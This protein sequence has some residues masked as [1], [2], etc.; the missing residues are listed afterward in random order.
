MSK[1]FKALQQAELE[2]TRRTE[3]ERPP[4][5]EPAQPPA[6]PG[7]TVVEPA[8]RPEA[9]TERRERA[10][11]LDEHLVGITAPDSAE[12]EQYRSLRFHLERLREERGSCVIAV[13]SPAPSD[14]K[15]TTAINLAAILSRDTESKVVLFDTDLRKPSIG[16]ALGLK[17]P[18]E[19]G[20]VNALGGNGALNL[21]DLAIR[22]TPS[23]LDVVL[24]GQRVESPYELLKSARLKD[25][26]DEAR[27]RY[28]Y[29]ILDT[30][31]VVAFADC[32]AIGERVDGFLIVVAAHRTP[33]KL[34]EETL[35]LL[36]P[37]KVLGFIFNDDD[38]PLAG[39]GA[40]YYY[41]YGNMAKDGFR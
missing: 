23:S 22:C 2:R 3:T 10:N 37:G 24:A 34:V 35:N 30:P 25:L 6:R 26:V 5:T 16:G 21:D 8:P 9:R 33:R 19:K 28:H 4:V 15:T 13:S 17:T 36:E 18:R 41:S 11:G 7:L 39:Y 1:F 40:Y 12:A 31:P 38:R 27:S 14:G 32:Q 29:V 20:L